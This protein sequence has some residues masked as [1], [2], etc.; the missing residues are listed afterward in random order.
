MH[1][2][3]IKRSRVIPDA[4]GARLGEEAQG[5]RGGGN[6]ADVRMGKTANRHRPGPP[7][8]ASASKAGSTEELIKDANGLRG[9]RRPRGK[10]LRKEST[11]REY[12]TIQVGST[13]P[14]R[15]WPRLDFGS[16]ASA[17]PAHSAKETESSQS[18]I[19]EN[20]GSAIDAIAEAQLAFSPGNKAFPFPHRASA[21]PQ[22]VRRNSDSG[23]PPR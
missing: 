7:I 4:I 23:S 17:R 14:L 19:P 22:S 6:A 8:A 10:T 16:P 20:F 13:I 9:S 2:A 15:S 11:W 18:L 1:D 12:T 3:T 5:A 21:R